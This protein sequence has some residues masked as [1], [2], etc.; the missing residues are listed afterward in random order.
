MAHSDAETALSAVISPT[1]DVM[2]K[3]AHVRFFC[4]FFWN[5]KYQINFD[6]SDLVG[7]I[8]PCPIH[9]PLRC[10]NCTLSCHFT[11]IGRDAEKSARALFL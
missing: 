4:R 1:S 8:G 11:N 6:H 3:K 9:G 5:L 7:S 2:L 10:R